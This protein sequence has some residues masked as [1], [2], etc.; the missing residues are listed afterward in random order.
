MPGEIGRES[1]ADDQ[2]DG[3]A[4]ALAEVE[5]TPRRRVREDLALGI[6]LERQTHGLRVVA[7][8]EQLAYQ[9]A[10]VEFRAA[11][12]ERHL[13]FADEDRAEGHQL[14]C[15]KFIVSPSATRYSLPSSRSS[16]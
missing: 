12:H 11:L 14:A 8:D 10:R 1:R 7:M 6:P 15:L 4:V 2:I 13:G 9:F 16:P 5:Q 3:A